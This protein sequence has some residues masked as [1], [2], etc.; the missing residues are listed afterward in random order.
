MLGSKNPSPPRY[1]GS[2]L[3]SQL[4]TK[5]TACMHGNGFLKAVLK[6]LFIAKHMK[7]VKRERRCP[8]CT[9]ETLAVATDKVTLAHRPPI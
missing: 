2:Y 5:W 3:E 1:M 8:C 7:E 4:S 6:E 9:S